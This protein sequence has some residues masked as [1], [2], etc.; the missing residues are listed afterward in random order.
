MQ[1]FQRISFLVIQFRY[2]VFNVILSLY[3]LNVGAK[4][5]S[6]RSRMQHRRFR[7]PILLQ[8]QFRYTSQ[9][10]ESQLCWRH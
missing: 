5:T 6:T 10:G 7:Q 4:P 1:Y 8:K 9:T 3:L 2:F